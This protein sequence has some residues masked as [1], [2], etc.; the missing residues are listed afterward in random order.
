MRSAGLDA[1]AV[2]AVDRARKKLVQKARN[3]DDVWDTSTTAE[4]AL[5]MCILAGFP[6]R[7]ARRR[8]P[9]SRE[10]ILRSGANA[11]L[12]ENSVVHDAQLMV[13]VDIE[14][15]AARGRSGTTVVRL[16]SA[17]EPEW[18]LDSY[19]DLLDSKTELEWNPQ[20]E[21]VERVEPSGL[22]LGRARREPLP[23][24]NRRANGRGFGPRRGGGRA[25]AFRR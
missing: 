9:G 24:A 16:A 3:T 6:D 21:R 15:R 12:G 7:V 20:A 11:E 18:L 25:H 5:L 8:R 1:R 17:I 19:S 10:L 2:G 4:Q 22:R 13:A 14:E 23:C